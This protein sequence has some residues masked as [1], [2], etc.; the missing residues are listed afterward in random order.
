MG[1]DRVD[2]GQHRDEDLTDERGV[3]PADEELLAALLAA[4]GRDDLLGRGRRGVAGVAG[5]NDLE[6]VAV[7]GSRL[8]EAEKSLLDGGFSSREVRVDVDLLLREV[9]ADLVVAGVLDVEVVG[10]E[11]L[12]DGLDLTPEVGEVVAF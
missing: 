3:G 1:L 2:V 5:V 7:L 9:Q 6:A 8:V 10:Q 11:E 4:D 12:E